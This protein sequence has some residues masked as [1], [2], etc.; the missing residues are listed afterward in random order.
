MSHRLLDDFKAYIDYD[1]ADV[2]KDDVLSLCLSASEGFLK[3][4]HGINCELKEITVVLDGDGNDYVYLPNI[5]SSISKVTIDSVELDITTVSPRYNKVRLKEGSFTSGIDNIS[6][7][8]TVGYQDISIPNNLK[9]AMYKLAFKLFKDTDESRD[10]I[11]N[12]KTNIKTGIDFIQQH[13]PDTFEFLI[14]PYIIYS[15]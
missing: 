15:V 13:L 4:T 9:V 5:I 1:L 8:Y 14:Q 7:T 6:I 12:Y 10:G 11:A 2:T 3:D